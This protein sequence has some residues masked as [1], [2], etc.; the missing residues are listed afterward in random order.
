MYAIHTTYIC[1]CSK[2]IYDS[3]RARVLRSTFHPQKLYLKKFIDKYSQQD[4]SIRYFG[5]RPNAWPKSI[6]TDDL[7]SI[8]NPHLNARAFISSRSCVWDPHTMNVPTCCLYDSIKS[9]SRFSPSNTHTFWGH[10][11]LERLLPRVK[12]FLTYKHVTYMFRC[13]HIYIYFLA[14]IFLVLQ[15]VNDHAWRIDNSNGQKQK[16]NEQLES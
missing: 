11:S 8:H 12:H 4:E 10:L 7:I 9:Q 1:R 14:L 16:K 3:S 6:T 2:S 13:I 15:S 5:L